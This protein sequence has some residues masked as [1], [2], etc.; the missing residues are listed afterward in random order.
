VGGLRNG[1]VAAVARI[2]A[3]L[4]RAMGA[5]NFFIDSEIDIV[6]VIISY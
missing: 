6:P 3:S 2:T 1:N 4:L 5:S